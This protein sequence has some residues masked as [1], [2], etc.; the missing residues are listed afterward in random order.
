MLWRIERSNS[1]A[2]EGDL[3]LEAYHPGEFAEAFE[4]S[5]QDLQGNTGNEALTL[6]VEAG[7]KLFFRVSAF[8]QGASVPYRLQVGFIPG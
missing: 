8:S 5:D 4:R 2:D 1:R 7:E 3:I 6:L